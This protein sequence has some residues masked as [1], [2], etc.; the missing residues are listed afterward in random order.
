MAVLS[1]PNL[2]INGQG[3][4]EFDSVIAVASGSETEILSYTVPVGK[5]LYLLLVQA[6]GNNVATYSVYVDASLVAKN[7]T[8]F[9]GSLGVDMPFGVP[10]LSGYK[11][12]S[13]SVISVTGIHNRP[14]LG[15][16]EARLSAILL[17]A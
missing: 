8:Y 7:R 16:F 17:E 4:N 5:A 6:S 1:L 13:G 11:I 9:G 10:S 2:S 3:L 15:D 12:N 14:M